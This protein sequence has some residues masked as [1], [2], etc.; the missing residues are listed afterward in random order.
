MM[1]MFAHVHDDQYAI[2][3]EC[4]WCVKN[5]FCGVYMIISLCQHLPTWMSTCACV[6]MKFKGVG[7]CSYDVY[8]CTCSWWSICNLR[9]V[10][11]MC[12][13]YFLWHIHDK[14]FPLSKC[15]SCTLTHKMTSTIINIDTVIHTYMHT[16]KHSHSY[17][18]ITPDMGC[19][20]KSTPHYPNLH[21]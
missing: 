21:M 18:Y 11:L 12:Q 10:Q 2:C 15:T 9:R 1:C 3:V 17:R 6:T 19:H 8:V 16:H 14:K 13:I 7:T 20:K 4:N 5:Y